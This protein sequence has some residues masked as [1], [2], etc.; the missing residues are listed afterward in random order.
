MND[1][2]WVFWDRDIRKRYAGQVVLVRNRRIWG[3]G[4]NLDAALTAARAEADCPDM[5]KLRIVVVPDEEDLSF[6]PFPPIPRSVPKAPP[7]TPS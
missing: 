4:E 3:A 1:V 7:G 2:D 5:A 6:Y